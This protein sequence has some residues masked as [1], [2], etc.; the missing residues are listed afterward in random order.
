MSLFT[1]AVLIILG[2]AAILALLSFCTK[3]RLRRQFMLVVAAGVW[4][5]ALWLGA[6]DAW[7]FRDGFPLPCPKCEYME[8][9]GFVALQSFFHGF[10]VD[11]LGLLAVAAMI[12]C[13][14][15][16]RGACEYV[17]LTIM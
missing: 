6:S 17:R 7:T 16:T 10:W 2:L 9:S 15:T 12:V 11:L 3:S 14:G 13:A 1:P 8:S 4:A 5:L